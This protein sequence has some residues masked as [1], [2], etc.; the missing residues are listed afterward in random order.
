M[1]PKPLGSIFN[2][3]IIYDGI[4]DNEIWFFDPTK[5][6]NIDGKLLLEPLASVKITNISDAV[7]TVNKVPSDLPVHA[8]LT[9]PGPDSVQP[10]YSFGACFCGYQFT[11]RWHALARFKRWFHRNI[12]IHFGIYTK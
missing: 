4:P 7:L 2:E 10:H 12:F 5:V 3:A 1:S 6:K 11:S 9:K 8:V